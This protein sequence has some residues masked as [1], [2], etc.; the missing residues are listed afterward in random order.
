MEL[1]IFIQNLKILIY[2]DKL[3]VHELGLLAVDPGTDCKESSGN[4][5]QRGLNFTISRKHF[6]LI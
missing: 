1:M 2:I 5:I 4:K 6:G 3:Y